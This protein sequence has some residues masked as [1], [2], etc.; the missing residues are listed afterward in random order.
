[1][2]LLFTMPCRTVGPGSRHSGAA[3]ALLIVCLLA[4]FSSAAQ[5]DVTTRDLQIAARTLGFL[6]PPFTGA[7]RMGLVYDAGSTRSSQQAEEVRRLLGSGLTVGNLRLQPLLVPL[8]E[9]SSA[10]VHMF[11][12]IEGAVDDAHALQLL[13][14]GRKLP[15]LTT[16]LEQVRAGVCAIGIQST[17]K[18]EILVSR[19]AAGAANTRFASVFRMMVVEL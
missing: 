8:E 14:A 5:A 17:P 12:L 10:N 13:L 18:V 9:I 3:M 4:L 6:D 7:I 16:D 19:A 11:F 15:C 1:M 2:R